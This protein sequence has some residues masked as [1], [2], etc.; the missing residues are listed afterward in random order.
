MH[1][2]ACLLYMTKPHGHLRVGLS[3]FHYADWKGKY[4]PAELPTARWLSYYAREFDTVEINNSFYRLPQKEQFEQWRAQV[5]RNFTFAVKYSQYGSHRRRLREPEEHLGL[6]CERVEGLNGRLGPVL[7]QLPSRWKADAPRLDDFLAVRTCAKR[8]VIEVRDP[9]W[10]N[11]EVYEVLRRHKAALC[12]H[13][14]LPNHPWIRTTSWSYIRFH[15]VGTQKYAGDYTRAHLKPYAE[16]MREMLD[17]GDDI[18][19]YFNNDA[20]GN[21]IKNARTLL[22]FWEKEHKYRKTGTE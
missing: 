22:S 12:V 10:L 6:F 15:G 7:V 2:C 4:Y 19:A 5:P 9:S 8:W 17:R 11:D 3:G 18:Y 21:A 1:V 16:R 20:G 13:D 14:L